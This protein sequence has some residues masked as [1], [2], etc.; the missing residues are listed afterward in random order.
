MAS[1]LQRAWKHWQ[2]ALGR[3]DVLRNGDPRAFIYHE[4]KAAAWALLSAK[5]APSGKPRTRA[6]PLSSAMWSYW[7]AGD[8][9][10]ARSVAND[11]LAGP[12]EEYFHAQAREVLTTTTP[13]PS[14]ERRKKAG[15]GG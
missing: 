7:N 4:R 1:R 14:R 13:A 11:L 5:L 2:V 10:A 12:Y 8:V 6:V 9:V 3:V 15:G